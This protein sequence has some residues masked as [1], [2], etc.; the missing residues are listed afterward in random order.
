M[1][2]LKKHSIP[3]NQNDYQFVTF[4]NLI[5]FDGELME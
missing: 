4:S 5:H 1:S 3:L 2:M